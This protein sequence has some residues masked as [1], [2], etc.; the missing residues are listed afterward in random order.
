MTRENVIPSGDTTAIKVREN[1]RLTTFASMPPAARLTLAVV[2]WRWLVWRRFS[3]KNRTQLPSHLQP[4][5]FKRL[6]RASGIF[7]SHGPLHFRFHTG[8]CRPWFAHQ[9]LLS[10]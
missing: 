10:L 6:V 7:D 8:Q 3:H 4:H 1:P 5:D 9:T 2:R